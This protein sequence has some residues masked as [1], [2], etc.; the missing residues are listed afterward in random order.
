MKIT[1]IS[2]LLLG[3]RA[4]QAEDCTLPEAAKS[5]L[6]T[7]LAYLNGLGNNKARSE[8]FTG[9]KIGDHVFF[10]LMH[11]PA[12]YAPG[13]TEVYIYVP[14]RRLDV[15]SCPANATWVNCVADWVRNPQGGIVSGS[16]K[17]HS[18]AAAPNV[19]TC[20]FTLQVPAW[21]P[22]AEDE[23][24]KKLAAEI[25]QELRD[26]NYNDARAV[27]I[28]DFNLD[29]PDIWIYVITREGSPAFQGCSFDPMR[30]PH[31]GWHLFGQSP[32]DS[33]KQ[34]IAERPYRLYPPP[35]GPFSL[36]E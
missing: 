21:K 26:F 8:V 17:G 29:D 1:A 25:L 7:Y 3:L 35:I 2:I 4:A 19:S 12:G 22:S 14:Q 15:I 16:E 34:Q 20:E 30:S 27:Y 18:T 33:L 6:K 5:C 23:R 9:L 13:Y 28:R 36:R 32:L 24:K 11:P 31:C 10:R